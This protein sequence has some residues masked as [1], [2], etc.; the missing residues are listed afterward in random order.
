MNYT[1]SE[2]IKIF[3]LVVILIAIELGKEFI[4][5]RKLTKQRKFYEKIITREVEKRVRAEEKLNFNEY[6]KRGYRKK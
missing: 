1:K 6:Q 5:Q 2:L 4:H 3:L